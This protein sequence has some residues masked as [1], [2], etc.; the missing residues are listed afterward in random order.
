MPNTDELILQPV[1]ETHKYI[2]RVNE[3]GAKIGRQSSNNLVLC[4]ESVSRFHCEVFFKEACFYIQDL[5]STTGTYVKIKDKFTL[6]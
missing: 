6:R 5:G 3:S 4:D 1:D 2:F